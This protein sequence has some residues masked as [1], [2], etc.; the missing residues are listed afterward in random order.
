MNAQEALDHYQML[1]PELLKGAPKDIRQW[2]VPQMA[3]AFEGSNDDGLILKQIVA[4]GTCRR[5]IRRLAAESG[6]T[7][8]HETE[9]LIRHSLK[10]F[11]AENGL[12]TKVTWAA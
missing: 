12:A 1:E 3:I 4:N 6:E 7:E 9:N 8:E 10:R 2:S 5:Y 11:I